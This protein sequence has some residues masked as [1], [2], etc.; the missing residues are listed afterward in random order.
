MPILVLLSLKMLQ[1]NGLSRWDMIAGAYENFFAEIFDRAWELAA[2][3]KKYEWV[4][5]YLKKMRF[6]HKEHDNFG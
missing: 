5:S 3:Q 1:M 2:G 6:A 4:L